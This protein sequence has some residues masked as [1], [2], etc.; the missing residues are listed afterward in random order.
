MPPDLPPTTWA[1]TPP[2][3]DHPH[4][5]WAIGGDLQPGTL[6]AAY[7]A[8]LFPMPV[9]GDV[10]WWSPLRRAV[11]PVEGFRPSRSLRRAARGYEIAFD[12]A[13]ESVITACADP[14]RPH[15]WIDAGFVSAYTRLHEAGCAHS[16]EAWDD[17]GLAGGLYG[18]ALGGLFAAESMFHHRRDASKAALLA[19]IEYLGAAGGAR[20]VDAQWATPHLLSL[21]AIEITRGEYTRRLATALTLPDPFARVG[22][23]RSDD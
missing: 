23:S 20:L 11:F 18:V 15:G 10:V 19:L 3:A 12:T 4:D 21:G 8:G 5:A 22:R 6:V 16:V 7:R 13:F 9:E 2:P 14:A 1:V 17:D